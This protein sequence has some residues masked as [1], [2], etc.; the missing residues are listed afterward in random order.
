[1]APLS[2]NSTNSIL[3]PTTAHRSQLEIPFTP[4]Q[5]VCRVCFSGVPPIQ[6]SPVFPEV[7]GVAIR[8]SVEAVK[9][10]I[11]DYTNS[12]RPKIYEFLTKPR[13]SAWLPPV[14][15]EGTQQFFRNLEIPCVNGKP[16]LLL[17]DLG[18]P[19]ASN[20]FKGSEHQ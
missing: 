3:F 19:N 15:D 5:A 12:L 17:H 20:L 2:S 11:Y 8:P 18:S 9:A 13:P 7:D 14:V 4:E 16:C 10:L 6:T 1:M